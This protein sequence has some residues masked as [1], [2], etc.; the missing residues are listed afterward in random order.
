MLTRVYELKCTTSKT[1]GEDVTEGEGQ[2][3]GVCMKMV[4]MFFA[5]VPLKINLFWPPSFYNLKLVVINGFPRHF[6]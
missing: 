4:S 5:S 6:H 2:D 1:C 3:K